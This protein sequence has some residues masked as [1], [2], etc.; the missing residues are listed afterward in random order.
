[1]F[2]SFEI[3]I[4]CTWYLKDYFIV[5]ISKHQ[6]GR[7]VVDNKKRPKVIEQEARWKWSLV[8]DRPI[9]GLIQSSHDQPISNRSFV[10]RMNTVENAQDLIGDS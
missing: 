4:N 10:S 1:M 8:V 2:T 5:E 3:W 9:I 6:V 7:T